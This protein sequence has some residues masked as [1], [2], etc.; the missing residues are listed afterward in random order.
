MHE[1]TKQRQ[2]EA[3][4]IHSI[5]SSDPLDPPDPLVRCRHAADKEWVTH[6]G[7]LPLSSGI[8]CTYLRTC[9]LAATSVLKML[10]PDSGGGVRVR[11]G[12]PSATRST[13]RRKSVV[14]FLASRLRWW[15]RN[16]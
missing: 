7:L 4:L 16:L 13:Y 14:S 8:S 3:H 10:A 15:L 9:R 5:H 12:K 6:S 2:S 11:I 1:Y